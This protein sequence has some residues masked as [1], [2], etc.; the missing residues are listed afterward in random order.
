MADD[1]VSITTLGEV[2]RG[3]ASPINPALMRSIASVTDSLWPNVPILP[4]MLVGATDGVY[5]RNV[6]IPCYGVQGLFM[7]RLD[8]R[9]HGRDERMSVRSF[10]EGETFL[11]NL[12]K[13]LSS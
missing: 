13:A 11:Y 9:I 6:G 4:Q 10:Y 8:L 1:K 12:V 7:D 2:A 5:L 3:P